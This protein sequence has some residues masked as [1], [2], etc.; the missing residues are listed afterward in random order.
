MHIIMNLY[1]EVILLKLGTVFKGANICGLA[2]AFM[3]FDFFYS[4]TGGN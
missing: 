3:T 4:N 1:E 2:I